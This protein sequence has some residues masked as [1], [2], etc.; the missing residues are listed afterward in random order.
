MKGGLT[1]RPSLG[2]PEKDGTPN[3]HPLGKGK[4]DLLETS[5]HHGKFIKVH[6]DS[7]DN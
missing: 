2:T 7:V 1:S 5:H 4:H 3:F 6:H